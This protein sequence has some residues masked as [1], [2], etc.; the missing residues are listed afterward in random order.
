MNEEASDKIFKITIAF[1]GFFPRV[2]G[3]WVFGSV[4]E[5]STYLKNW[6][7]SQNQWRPWVP[8]QEYKITLGNPKEGKEVGEWMEKQLVNK[9]LHNLLEN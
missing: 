3:F 9:Q 1:L 4:F 5:L 8:H 2:W 6:R 7:H